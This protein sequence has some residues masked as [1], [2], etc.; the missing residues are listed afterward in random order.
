MKPISRL[1]LIT[2][3]ASLAG[4]VSL[5]NSPS[6]MVLPGTGLSFEQFRLDDSLCQQYAYAQIG[7]VSANQAA[8][9]SGL[10]SAAAGTALGAGAG[11]LIGGGTGAAV[12]AGAGL[13]AG[14][15]AGSSS[16]SQSAYATQQAYDVAY[17]Q[18]MYAKGHRVPVTGQFSTAPSPARPSSRPLTVPPPPAGA[19]PSP[20]PAR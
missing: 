14:G 20:P 11:A 9:N 17:I 10:T 6:V 16:A 19:P 8:T 7:G 15:I 12:G 1:V 5:P 18:C 13:A 3:T 2:L 4:C